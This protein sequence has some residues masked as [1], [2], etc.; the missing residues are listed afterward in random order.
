[1]YWKQRENNV[2]NCI[3]IDLKCLIDLASR[4]GFSKLFYSL[5]QKE[6]KKYLKLFV[7]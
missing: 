6:S 2:N 5:T 7:L 4:I 1:M 3:N